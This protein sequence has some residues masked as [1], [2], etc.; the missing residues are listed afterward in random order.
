MSL[1]NST[2]ESGNKYAAVKTILWAT[3]SLGLLWTYILCVGFLD[4]TIAGVKVLDRHILIA[5][6]AGSVFLGLL[7]T[8]AMNRRVFSN[9]TIRDASLGASTVVVGLVLLD[10]GYS[11]FLNSSQSPSSSGDRYSDPNTWIG[12]LYPDLYFPTDKNFRLHKPGHTVAGSHYGDMYRPALL[13]SPLLSSSV[14]S[15]KQ[16][17]ISINNEGFRETAK[18]EGHKILAIGD[19]FTFGWG[20]DQGLTW[21]KLLERSIGEAIYN[22]GIHDASPKQEFLLLED[23]I[24]SHKLDLRGGLLL[25]MIFEGNDLEDS[26]DDLHPVQRSI[27]ISG[28][29]FRDTIIET[30]CGLP[31]VIRRESVIGKFKDGRA[32]FSGLNGDSRT[33]GHNVI[34]GIASAFPLYVSPRFGPKLFSPTQLK[35]AQNSAQYVESHQH[36]HAL[37]KTFERMK[38]LAH[39]EGFRVVLIIAPSDARLYGAEFEDFPTLSEKPHFNEFVARLADQSGFEVVNLEELLRS[40]AAKELLYF[41]DDDHWNERGHMAVADILNGVLRPKNAVLGGETVHTRTASSQPITLEQN[42]QGIQSRWG[43]KRVH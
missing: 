23:V 4:E 27:S 17:T 37:E 25:W 18:L 43:T 11:V 5:A 13:A 20:I 31:S 28:W 14:F 22:M 38:S 9:T 19:S 8:W 10:L 21:V 29:L 16:V 33:K 40:L 2:R 12:E 24:H 15:K 7:F 26:Y 42:T 35:R 34:D 36:R 30:L 1:S 32:T 39:M 6:P 41:R 3:I